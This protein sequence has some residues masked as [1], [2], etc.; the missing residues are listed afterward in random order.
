M[1]LLPLALL[2]FST[3][4][5]AGGPLI[6]ASDGSSSSWGTNPTITLDI[7]SGDC[8]PYDTTDM[9]A[10][11]EESLNVWDDL[12]DVALTFEIS[13][14]D[15]PDVDGANYNA[16]LVTGS[17]T[18]LELAATEDNLNP[19]AFD[20]DGEIIAAIAGSVN[21]FFVLGVAGAVAFGDSTLGT[22]AEGQVL[23]NCRCIADH[24]NEGACTVG[25]T[26]IEVSEN[27]LSYT[28]SHE[29]GHMINLDH[30]MANY[31]LYTSSS[32]SDDTN[33]PVMFPTTSEADQKASAK[34][35]D[36]AALGAIY[37]SASFLNDRC[38]VQGVLLESDGDEMECVNIEATSDDVTDTISTVTG[39]LAPTLDFDAGNIFSLD[40]DCSSNCGNFEFYLKSDKAYTL[41]MTD[42][43][44]TFTGGSSVGP[45]DDQRTDVEEE[46]IATITAAQCTAGSTINLGEI[47]SASGTEGSSGS[48]T[49]SSSSGG[50]PSAGGSSRGS[51]E[52]P[53]GYGCSLNPN[54]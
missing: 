12:N 18:A 7:E 45:C 11:V 40:F 19:I 34:E 36:I 14:G 8:G 1:R 23:I 25:G 46:V 54:L 44:A 43:P 41:T 13:T 9:Q 48:S 22:I 37:P 38:L 35:D 27:K 3:P 26:T 15:V 52:N 29:V 2:L 17:G 42:I 4:A 21:R 33:L 49:G 30:S 53:V 47:T 31:D 20:D 10:L 24:P 16:Y 6:T 5:L 51:V 39:Y 32:S 28:I 50:N